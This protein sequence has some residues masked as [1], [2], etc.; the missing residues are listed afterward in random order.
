MSTMPK[1]KIKCISKKK[2][3]KHCTF[4]TAVSFNTFRGG[5]GDSANFNFFVNSSL[6]GNEE[7]FRP[8][9]FNGADCEPIGNFG[10]FGGREED[11]VGIIGVF[12][13]SI[14]FTMCL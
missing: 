14:T 5:V 2:I 10:D 7:R 3:N 1:P 4:Y 9:R 11:R 12:G 6:S 13:V 8:L